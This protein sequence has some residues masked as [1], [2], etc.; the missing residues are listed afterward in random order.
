M[1]STKRRQV[2]AVIAIQTALIIFLGIAAMVYRIEGVGAQ[3]GAD[4]YRKALVELH[5]DHEA[6]LAKILLYEGEDLQQEY[7]TTLDVAVRYGV[8]TE[9]EAMSRRTQLIAHHLP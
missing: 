6:A 1:F 5:E 3:A 2:V 4:Y 7:L 8:V 9:R